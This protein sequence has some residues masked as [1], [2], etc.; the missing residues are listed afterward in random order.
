M[1]QTKH[2]LATLVLLL[3]SLTASAEAV[4]IDGFWYN[5]VPKAKQAEV[6]KPSDG[7]KCSGAITIPATVELG[8][9][10][11]V[12][13]EGVRVNK[14]SQ[15][16]ISIA[17]ASHTGDAFMM[18]SNTGISFAYNITANGQAISSG[19][20]VLTVNPDTA[21]AGSVVLQFEKPKKAI[22][23]GD[24]IGNVIFTIAV[25]TARDN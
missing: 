11:T 22:Y 10:I 16:D 25:N 18:I 15:V 14:G 20:N 17:D 1:K 19:A 12:S 3:C 2:L 21:S 7:T 23:A 13:A 8:D 9:E 4:Q 24:Y 5:L 6:T